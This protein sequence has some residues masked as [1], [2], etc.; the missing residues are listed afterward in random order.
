M[1]KEELLKLTLAEQEVQAFGGVVTARRLTI[2]EAAQ[3]EREPE[4]I[5]KMI[6]GVSLALVNP[7]MSVEELN[8]I[9]STF[10]EDFAKII[11]AISK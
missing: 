6:L 11:E 5:N 1:T 8:N 4:P 2:G 7:K 9:P 10:A 3:V